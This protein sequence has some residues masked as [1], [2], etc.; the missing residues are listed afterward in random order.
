MKKFLILALLSLT[1][2]AISS[3]GSG[4]AH[5]DAYSDNY[6]SVEENDLADNQ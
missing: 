2:V 4:K 5:C 1:T 3:C 6:I